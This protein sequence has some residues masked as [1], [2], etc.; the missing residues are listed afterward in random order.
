MKAM[1]QAGTVALGI[2]SALAGCASPDSYDPSTMYGTPVTL[3]S[4]TPTPAQTREVVVERVPAREVV[5]ER[6]PA[7]EVVVE[8]A[9]GREIVIERAPA[10]EVV[11]ER[12][13]GERVVERYVERVPAETG[14]GRAV[15][16]DGTVISY[17]R[18]IVVGPNT[19]SVTVGRDEVVRFVAAD[20]GRSFIW[21]FN[22][23][24]E[25]SFPL[26]TIAP[27]ST[28]MTPGVM[29]N[30]VGPSRVGRAG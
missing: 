19:R 7:R 2:A 13:P 17:D 6:A 3:R 12:A 22:T 4:T 26:A 28:P 16:T 25:T 5:V 8:R 23:T 1:M 27:A 11:V 24:Q 9:T 20:T 29:V 15:A 10:R 30:V 14:P 21:R 18:E